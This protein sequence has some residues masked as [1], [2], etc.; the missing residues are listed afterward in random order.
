LASS[1][2]SYIGRVF[3]V[4]YG[5]NKTGLNPSSQR[6]LKREKPRRKNR[7]ASAPHRKLTFGRVKDSKRISQIVTLASYEFLRIDGFELFGVGGPDALRHLTCFP[8]HY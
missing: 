8:L 7:R 1:T 4:D 6:T 2:A 3:D 5:S